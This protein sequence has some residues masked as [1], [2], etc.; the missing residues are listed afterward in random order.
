MF[1]AEEQRRADVN[2]MAASQRKVFISH[3]WL[4][5]NKNKDGPDDESDPQRKKRQMISYLSIPAK[6]CGPIPGGTLT[7]TY[8]RWMHAPP[9]PPAHYSNKLPLNIPAA[10]FSFPPGRRRGPCLLCR[11]S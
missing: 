10:C 6:V 8:P 4:K 9:P 11:F 2:R 1:R 7:A 3:C 5:K